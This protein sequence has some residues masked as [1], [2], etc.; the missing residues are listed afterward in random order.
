MN[1]ERLAQVWQDDISQIV[2]VWPFIWK[3]YPRGNWFVL[4]YLG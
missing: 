2:V 4:G 3:H 1:N